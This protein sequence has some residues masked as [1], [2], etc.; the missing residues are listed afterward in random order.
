MDLEERLERLEALLRQVIGKI[1]E[2][3][4]LLKTHSGAEEAA[5]AARLTMAMLYPASIAID[6]ARRVVEVTRLTGSLD[7]LSRSII[8]VLAPCEGLS[9]SE[10]TRRVKALRGT[11]SRR[12]IAGRLKSLESRGLVVNIGTSERPRYTL[13]NCIEAGEGSRKA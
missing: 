13:Y 6:A 9:I 8:E 10:V 5:I 4:L 11:A 3:E 2:I 1:A 12:I 7:P